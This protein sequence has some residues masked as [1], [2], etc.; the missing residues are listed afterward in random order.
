MRPLRKIEG[1]TVVADVV[2]PVCESGDFLA[3]NRAMA[4]VQP[5]A[6]LAVSSAGAYGFVQASNYNS[7]PRGAEVLVEGDRWRVIRSRETYD[8]LIKGESL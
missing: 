6:W 8:D 2:G 1:E 7:R 4:D 5:G 3:R